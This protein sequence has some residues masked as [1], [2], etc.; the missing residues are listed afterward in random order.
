MPFGSLVMLFWILS[1]GALSYVF[2]DKIHW[3]GVEEPLEYVLC[4]ISLMGTTMFHS[5]ALQSESCI[6]IWWILNTFKFNTLLFILNVNHCWPHIVIHFLNRRPTAWGSSSFVLSLLKW[7][8][9]CIESVLHKHFVTFHTSQ[10]LMAQHCRSIFI[11]HFTNN[12]SSDVLN[13][14]VANAAS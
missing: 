6:N 8:V 4:Q 10:H 5:A 13:N 11:T 1:N 3:I 7:L 9:S 14:C 2:W 12:F